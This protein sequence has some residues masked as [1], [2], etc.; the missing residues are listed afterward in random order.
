MKKL[1]VVFLLAGCLLLAGCAQQ[2]EAEPKGELVT[3]KNCGA[4]LYNGTNFVI[5]EPSLLLQEG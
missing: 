3:V 2:E 5:I 4:D 1:S